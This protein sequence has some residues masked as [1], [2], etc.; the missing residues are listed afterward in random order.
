MIIRK[1]A[2]LSHSH[3]GELLIVVRLTHVAL[4]LQEMN[5]MMKTIPQNSSLFPSVLLC[6]CSMSNKTINKSDVFF[7]IMIY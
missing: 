7:V 6:V 5:I 1:E 4:G 3:P 2:N